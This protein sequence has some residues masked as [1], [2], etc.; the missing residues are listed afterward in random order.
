MDA[1]TPEPR[2]CWIAGRAEQGVQAITVF[3]PFDGTEV[4]SVAVPGPDQ[5]E[6]AVAAAAAVAKDF[7]RTPAHVRARALVQVSEALA[8]RAEE[9]A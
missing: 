2:P 9:I 4:A 3:H 5:V 8:D 7:R 6:R 1:T